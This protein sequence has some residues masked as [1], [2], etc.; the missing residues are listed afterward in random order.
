ML[1]FSSINGMKNCL[2]KGIGLTLCPH[3]SIK[4]ELKEKTLTRLKLD[5]CPDQVSLIMIWHSEKWCSPLLTHFM[6]LAEQEMG[7]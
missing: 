7:E 5:S 6:A 1:E 4:N 3:I 2:K